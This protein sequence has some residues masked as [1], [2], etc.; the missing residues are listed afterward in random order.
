MRVSIAC[1]VKG[2]HHLDDDFKKSNHVLTI[3][4]GLCTHKK[5]DKIML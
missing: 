2:L 3:N 4:M 1:K 5:G